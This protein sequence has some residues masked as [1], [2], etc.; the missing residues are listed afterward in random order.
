V[1]ACAQICDEIEKRVRLDKRTTLAFDFSWQELPL[2]KKKRGNLIDRSKLFL[3]FR[4]FF[5][6]PS[7]PLGGRRFF[8][9]KRE[10]ESGVEAL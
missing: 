7:S 6:F 3:E 9:S 8:V 4:V 5:V 2:A 10:S 1:C